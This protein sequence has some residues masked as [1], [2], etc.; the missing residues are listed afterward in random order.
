MK[1]SGGCNC[2][3]VRYCLDG[4]P[5]RVGICHCET[6]RKETGSA[7]SYFGVWPKSA[8]TIAGETG[9]WQSRSGSRHFCTSCGSSLFDADGSDEVEFRLGTLDSPPADLTP[10]YEL[11]TVRREHWLIPSGAAQFEQDRQEVR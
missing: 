9:S 4:D 5:L 3:R 2:G 7:F 6:C 11:W 10:A 1:L 8:A